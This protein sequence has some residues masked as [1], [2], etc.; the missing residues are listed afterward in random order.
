MKQAQNKTSG[1]KNEHKQVNKLLKK[2]KKLEKII[3]L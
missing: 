3:N 2:L 1:H